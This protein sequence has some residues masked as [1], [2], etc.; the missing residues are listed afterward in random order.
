MKSSA[1]NSGKRWSSF[2]LKHLKDL[3]RGRTPT[4]SI[5]TQLKRTLDSIYAKA[6]EMHL[7]LKHVKA[8]GHAHAHHGH[9]SKGMSRGGSS[10]GSKW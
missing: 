1:K 2:D 3:I 6:S 4:Q 5:A 8:G 7:S 10:R 9:M